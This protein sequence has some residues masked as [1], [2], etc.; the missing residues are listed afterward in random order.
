MSSSR[1]IKLVVQ[2]LAGP[3]RLDRFLKERF[4]SWGRQAI[5]K[6]VNARKVRVNGQHV[7]L[8]SWQLENG[9][10]MEILETPPAK[11]PAPESFDDSWI[12]KEEK[13]LVV[14]N[15][16]AGLLS[17]PVRAGETDNLLSLALQ[18]FG[19]LSLF[20]RL[21]RDTSGVV[22]LTRHAAINRYLDTAFKTS[23]VIKE[24]LALVAFSTALSSEGV[25]DQ[26]IGAHP[27][28]RDMMSVVD[29][30]GRRAVTR[31]QV[32]GEASG[33]RLVRLWPETGRMHQLRVHLSHGG[34]PILGDRLYGPGPGRYE[35]L[36]LHARK[37]SLPDLDKFPARRF[38]APLP[39]DFELPRP[40]L[41]CLRLSEEQ[42]YHR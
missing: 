38:E 41:E 7:W 35:R 36:M 24:Y 20:H 29:R 39:E 37:I 1:P 26:R 5:G 21:D 14:V 30:G 13:D 40:L 32:L 31:Y 6:L 19:P 17:Q 27:R 42:P 25:I 12:L 16:P 10:L 22:L 11:N 33:L 2:G 15:K 34:A 18:R 4:P 8:S 28:R 9:D 23:Q 3:T